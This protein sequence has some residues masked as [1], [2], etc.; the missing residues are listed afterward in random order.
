[1]VIGV[2]SDKW[3]FLADEFEYLLEVFEFVWF[4][5]HDGFASGLSSTST[6]DTV[7]I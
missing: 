6:T 7:N 1:V 3:D 2:V 4:A 5:E